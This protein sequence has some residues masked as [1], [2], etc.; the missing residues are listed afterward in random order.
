[1]KE[2]ESATTEVPV[3]WILRVR[4]ILYQL[5]H[6]DSERGKEANCLGSYIPGFIEDKE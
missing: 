2:T 4:E 6:E 1:M 3:E 5:A